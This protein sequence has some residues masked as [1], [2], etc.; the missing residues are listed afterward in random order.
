MLVQGDFAGGDL[1]GF[2]DR[3]EV[4]ALGVC[5]LVLA[6]FGSDKGECLCVDAEMILAGGVDPG[7]GVDSTREVIMQVG[8]FGHAVEESAKG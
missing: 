3:D 7:L 8:A 2:A 5:V 6:S 1:S 4:L